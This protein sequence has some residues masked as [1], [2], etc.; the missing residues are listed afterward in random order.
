MLRRRAAPLI[1]KYR[2]GGDYRPFSRAVAAAPAPEPAQP[3]L[4]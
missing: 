2:L 1:A 4:F 3:T